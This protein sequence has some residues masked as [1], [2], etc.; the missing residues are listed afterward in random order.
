MNT[1]APPA[2]VVDAHHH[3]WELSRGD[4]GWLTA[5]LGLIHRDF[6]MDDYRRVSPPG[7][8][9]S[10]LVQ[11]APTVAETRFLL[12]VARGCSGSVGAV[13]GYVDLD[14]DDAADEIAQLAGDPYLRGLRPM[15][16]DLD[17]PGWI[18]GPRVDRAL[19]ALAAS[20]L[21]FDALV[22]ARELPALLRMIER[23][24]ELPVVIDHGAKPP[25]ASAEWEPWAGWIRRLAAHPQVNCKLSGLV[26][27]AAA[28]WSVDTLRPYV[29]H[30]LDAF[31]SGRLMW[32]SDWPVVIL[33]GG[34]DRWWAATLALLEP[35]RPLER[36]AIL[37]GN[38]ARFYGL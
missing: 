31:G 1:S 29:Q 18:L 3:V 21:R 34:M 4:Y 26:T 28:D 30:L 37:G 17:D 38:A 35:M 32:G 2:A 6:T 20:R 25:I 36:A 11:A 24:P 16:H 5:D 33:G 10:V 7:V 15:L 23:H 12:D 8:V 22:R 27:E 13:V 9:A 19:E 14:R